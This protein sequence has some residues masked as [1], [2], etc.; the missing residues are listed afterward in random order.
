MIITKT[1]FSMSFIGGGTVIP[2]LVVRDERHQL[3]EYCITDIHILCYLIYEIVQR[4]KNKS[5][6]FDISVSR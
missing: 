1:P 6:I 4:Y 2:E 5:L 3:R